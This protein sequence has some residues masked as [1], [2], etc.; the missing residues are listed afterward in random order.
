MEIEGKS[1]EKYVDLTVKRK[2]PDLNFPMRAYVIDKSVAPCSLIILGV[3][4]NLTIRKLATSLYNLYL[5]EAFPKSFM[6]LGSARSAMTCDQFRGR[7]NQALKLV[8]LDKWKG[9]A[10]HLSC[11]AVDLSF[12]QSFRDFA[13]TLKDLD[14]NHATEADRIYYLAMPSSACSDVNA[15]LGQAGLSRE[16]MEVRYNVQNNPFPN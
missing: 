11:H 14:G 2:A 15:M 16:H 6:V 1:L 9:F 3:T 4:G 10:S 8:D 7:M 13:D 5:S 12:F